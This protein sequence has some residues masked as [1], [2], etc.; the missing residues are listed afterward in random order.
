MKSN[1]LTLAFKCAACARNIFNN[2][3]EAVG[4]LLSS[5]KVP[6][7]RSPCTTSHVFS[8]SKSRHLFS[9]TLKVS[10]IGVLVSLGFILSDANVPLPITVFSS[11]LDF[12]HSVFT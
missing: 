7:F 5:S 9:V 1:C 10:I 4:D 11:F 12:K 6:F 3:K 8:L 2:R